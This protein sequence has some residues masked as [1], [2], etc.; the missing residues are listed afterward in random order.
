MKVSRLRIIAFTIAL[1]ALST[2][3]LSKVNPDLVPEPIRTALPAASNLQSFEFLGCSGDWTDEKIQPQAWQ[4]G[5]KGKIT[6]LI[7]HPETCGYTIGTNP[8]A[9][10]IG[11]S[12]DLSYSMSNDD[13]ALAACYCEYWASFELKSTPE[14]ISKISINGADAALM[15]SLPER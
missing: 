5:R 2:Y 4:T 15:S 11:S 1:L 13:G 10:I 8:K 6:L 9:S 14:K 7:K 12:V 3:A